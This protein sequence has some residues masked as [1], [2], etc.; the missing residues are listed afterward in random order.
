MKKVDL[1]PVVWTRVHLRLLEYR[2]SAQ[3][4]TARLVLVTRV[5]A[6]KAL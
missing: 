6:M 4:W 3:Q 2:L 1:E 5:N